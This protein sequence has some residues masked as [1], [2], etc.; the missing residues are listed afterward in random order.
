MNEK[1]CELFVA[2]PSPAPVVTRSPTLSP[3][4]TVTIAPTS[5]PTTVAEKL[6][7]SMDADEECIEIVTFSDFKQAIEGAS[8]AVFCGDFR[9][10]KPDAELLIL[11]SDIQIVCQK[12]CTI[13]GRGMHILISGESTQAE[14]QQVKFM[15]SDES[16]VQIATSSTKSKITFCGCQ[17]WG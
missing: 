6:C 3:A 12:L 16:A 2:S 15:D 8:R 17:F 13:S 10:Q 7:S 11:T 14:L 5:P 9:V 1:S 4:P